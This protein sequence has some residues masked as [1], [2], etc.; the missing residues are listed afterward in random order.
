MQRWSKFWQIMFK[1]SQITG[2][3]GLPVIDTSSSNQIAVR[4]GL[5]FRWGAPGAMQYNAICTSWSG[6]LSQELVG[7]WWLRMIDHDRSWLS[8][9]E[10]PL[11][12]VPVHRF[13]A[14]FGTSDHARR[15]CGEGW[16]GIK[17]TRKLQCHHCLTFS[18]MRSYG[19]AVHHRKLNASPTGF[20]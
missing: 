14:I 6:R 2:V 19:L 15:I 11:P 18:Y 12:T 4:D 3:P 17:S 13:W 10:D 5:F 9:I 1:L 7:L 20:P 8:I 16:K